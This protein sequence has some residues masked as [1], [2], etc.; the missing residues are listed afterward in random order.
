MRYTGKDVDPIP[1][2]LNYYWEIGYAT[3]P[4]TSINDLSIDTQNVSAYPNPFT[5]STTIQVSEILYNATLTIFNGMGQPV[6]QTENVSGQTIVIQRDDLPAGVY[7]VQLTQGGTV[8]PTKRIV[9]V[10]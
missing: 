8:I 1:S 4:I 6:R 10:D 5:S 9:I 3:A 2:N 7:V